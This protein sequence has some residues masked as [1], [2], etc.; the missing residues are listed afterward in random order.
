MNFIVIINIITGLIKVWCIIVHVYSN[1]NLLHFHY[2]INLTDKTFF[3]QEAQFRLFSLK[4][5]SH[6]YLLVV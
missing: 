1:Y 2:K 4:E 3:L 6:N 5:V